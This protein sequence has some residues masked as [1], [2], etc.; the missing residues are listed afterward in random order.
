MKPPALRHPGRWL[1]L[2]LL[3]PVVLG[4]LRVKLDV[5]VLNLLPPGLPAV[6]GLRLHQ[7]Y[8]SNS[9]ELIIT[10]Q[11]ERPD[12]AE[13]V[14]R[15]L[16][17]ALRRESRLTASAVWQPPWL[18][19]PGQAAELLACL[20]FNQPPAVFGELASRLPPQKL[21]DIA[22]ETRENLAVSLS[23]LEIARSSYD[24]FG[25]TRLPENVASAA[26]GPTEGQEAF[27]SEDGAYRVLYVQAAGDLSTYQQCAQWL[28]EVRQ[29]VDSALSARTEGEKVSIGYTG[30]PAFVAEISSGMERDFN[31]SIVGTAAV[32]AALFWLAHRRW[33][34][35]L[36]LLA[37]LAVI[38]GATL[39][40]GGLVFGAIN[41]VSMGF[42]AVLLGL[43]V[44]YAVVHYQ[45]ALAHPDLS[46]PRVRRAIAP[47]ILWAAVT[48]ISAFLVLNLGGL[49]GLAQLGTLVGLGVA[50]A[51][52]VMVFEFLPP[53]F[54]DRRD[55]ETQPVVPSPSASPPPRGNT[56]HSGT[57]PRRTSPLGLT[58]ALVVGASI[59][60]CFGLPRIDPTGAALRPRNSQAYATLAEVQRQITRG[61]E[62]LVI[63]VRGQNE[64]AVAQRL[65]AVQSELEAAV[66]KRVI[67]GY[68]LPTAL[69][70]QPEFQRANR[71]T[72]RRLA[73][74]RESFREAARTNGF[75]APSLAL[76][77]RI[78]DTWER[79]AATQG[80]FWPTNPASQWVSQKFAART[81]TNVFAL[82][83]VT[84]TNPAG[85]QIS[86][87]ESRLPR[88]NVWLTGWELLG[89]AVF[90]LVR[91]NLWKLVAPMV[92]LVLLSLWLAFR[93]PA[94]VLLS[95]GV[96]ALSGVSLLTAMRLA[97]WSWNLLNL[98]AIP[99][100]LGTGVDYSI[101]MQLALRRHQG[102]LDLAHR[103]VGRALLLC[104]ATAITGFGALAWSSNAGMAS[105]GQVC[106]AGI[107]ANMLIA[108]FLLPA[109]WQALS[110]PT[111]PSVLYRGDSWRLGMWLVRRL[112]QRWCELLARSCMA[113]YWHAVPERRQ[114]VSQ[115]LM[116]ALRDDRVAATR[117]ARSLYANFG[118]KIAH[119][120]RYEA[121]LSI[122]HLLGASTGWEHFEQARASGRGVLLLTVHL[123]NW[124][125]GA[126]HLARQDVALQVLTLAEPGNRFTRLRQAARARWNVETFVIGNDP[127][128]FVEII[129]R[130]EA[131]AAIALLVDRP[132]PSTAVTVELFG[133]PFQASIAAAELARASGC[134]L[135]PVLLP[136]DQGLYQACMLPPIPYDRARLR[137][138]ETR[139]LLTQNILRAFEPFIRKHL[140]QWYHFVPVWPFSTFETSHG[141]A[142]LEAEE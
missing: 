18:E 51:A 70:P 98:M 23:P 39:A 83:L 108:V 99:L 72:A 103:S 24:P 4:L 67:A 34:P 64:T 68:R 46:I 116:P 97:G 77:E 47:S 60:L 128:A 135:L 17:E 119:L 42:A 50:L 20:W 136:R 82:G 53:L 22:A 90:D 73:A 12:H 89:G 102:D 56:S 113:L 19:N 13:D 9:R 137:D 81:P 138:R 129:R 130:L 32:I 87:L 55:A 61:R 76:T 134:V 58:S 66:T 69:W 7:Q 71:D 100:V 131:G 132:P 117:A 74:Q 101:F 33:K 16:A 120:L 37:L 139:R 86:A 93:H 49:P 104:G 26:P 48:T 65:V 92:L 59:V 38:L 15:S 29:V 126:P 43:A 31:L 8:F 52:C 140:D 123:G 40:L 62:P 1:W 41:V 122:D 125:F 78:L 94:E 127:F 54:P 21:G 80:V 141:H 14:A 85:A 35:M 2:A 107:A 133:R 96:L 124:E 111:G 114:M 75:A 45:E 88:E 115:N 57:Q 84:L 25:L 28:A 109:W 91:A 10:V 3:V 95:V 110:R 106:A 118:L 112:P 36:W 63:V 5:D 30:R 27:V 142:K 105:L 6:E 44:D 79:A 121:G 11:A